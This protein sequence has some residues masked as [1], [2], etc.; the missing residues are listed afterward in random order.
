MRAAAVDEEGRVRG[1]VS[2]RT[3][4]HEGRASVVERFVGMLLRAGSIAPESPVGVG[5]SL[6]SPVE[7]ETGVM[8]NPP[9][10]PGWDGYTL[11]P[12]LERRLSLPVSAANDATLAALAEHRY[13]AGSPYS[14]F[15]YITLSTGIGGGLILDGKPYLGARGFAGE[16]GHVTIDRGGPVCGCGN[17]GCLEALASGTAVA[18]IA[19]ERIAAGGEKGLLHG[20][21][22]A[23]DSE[24]VFRAARLGDPT[25]QEIVQE[26]GESLGAG[27]VSLM[28]AFDL[29]AFVVGGGMSESLDLLLPGIER[30]VALHAMEHHRE[31]VPIVKSQLGDDAG[32]IGAGVM[33]LG[34]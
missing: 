19:R 26:V 3:H 1:R 13:G 4:A 2:Q 5:L 32:L 29:E 27:I 11:K 20:H 10:L 7:P 9:N 12:L 17:V 22:G 28:A 18:R 16:V 14:S 6:A 33:A 31:G 25:A 34:G 24:A 8:R 15:I 23:L 21:G 30:R